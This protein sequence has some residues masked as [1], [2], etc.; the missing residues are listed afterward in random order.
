MGKDREWATNPAI[1]L[2]YAMLTF[3]ALTVITD[4]YAFKS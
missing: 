2:S 4:F 1:Q 3:D